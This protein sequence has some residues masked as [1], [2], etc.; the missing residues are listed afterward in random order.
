M[1]LKAR[2]YF[3]PS[4]SARYLEENVVVEWRRAYINY[5]G[6]KKLIK[7]VDARYKQRR[8][9]ELRRLQSHSSSSGS[10]RTWSATLDG[11]RKRQRKIS[12]A[13]SDG[14]TSHD[15]LFSRKD[16]GER[17]DDAADGHVGHSAISA[18]SSSSA[19]CAPGSAHL[20]PVTLDG[21]GLS[22][23]WH[24]DDRTKAAGDSDASGAESNTTKTAV[25]PDADE[26]CSSADI[27]V[28]AGA[29]AVTHAVHT[30]RPSTSRPQPTPSRSDGSLFSHF[31]RSG[32][33]DGAGA[34]AGAGADAAKKEKNRKR[35][36]AALR[37]AE[38]SETIHTAFDREERKFFSA[39]DNEVDRVVAFYISHERD[40]T[41]RYEMLARQ[42]QEVS[43]YICCSKL[44]PCAGSS[45]VF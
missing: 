38:I 8:T 20:P 37:G 7:R 5:R 18:Q 31:N 26:P 13:V 17:D 16:R 21:T 11:L 14:E 35:T 28:E 32:N 10:L 23:A 3:T 2:P 43:A 19:E 4:S 24:E 30:T 9:L 6:L 27:D 25:A 29:P 33:K 45:N 1:I 41:K 42:L 39:L 22:L 34:G 12:G 44:S 36:N 40:M 15:A